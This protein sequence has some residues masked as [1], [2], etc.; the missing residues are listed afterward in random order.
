MRSGVTP[1]LENILAGVWWGVRV[2]MLRAYSPRHEF[3]S[4][5][6]YLI[7]A[8]WNLG[9][10]VHCSLTGKGTITWTNPMQRWAIAHVL[11]FK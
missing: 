7:H 8:T 1:F 10:E 9:E 4:T 6:S 5:V 11:R 3:V 2:A